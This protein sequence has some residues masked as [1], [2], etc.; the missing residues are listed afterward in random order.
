[1]G[2][3]GPELMITWE[4]VDHARSLGAALVSPHGRSALVVGADVA[5]E[6]VAGVIARRLS[7]ERAHV[8]RERDHHAAALAAPPTARL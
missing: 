4:M 5:G 8:R 6:M 3:Q 7:E 1:M 2:W